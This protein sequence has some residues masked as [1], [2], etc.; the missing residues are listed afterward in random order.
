MMKGIPEP[1]PPG[2]CWRSS[3][4]RRA[5][6][7]AST[8]R[9]W[10]AG[11]SSAGS[12][13]R[14]RTPSARSLRA[15]HAIGPAGVGKSRLVH[16]FVAESRTGDGDPRAGVCRTAKESRSGRSSGPS[17][18]RG[19]R[20]QRDSSAEAR[21]KLAG[22]LPRDGDDAAL[23]ATRSR[24]LLGLGTQLA[25][26]RRRSGRSG[27]C[28]STSRRPAARGRLRRHPVGRVDVPRSAS[29]TSQTGS[30]ALP[31][32]IVC[33]ARPEIQ[34]SAPGWAAANVARS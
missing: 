22:L 31:V 7:E 14:S 12:T 20:A 33:I 34:E 26:S 28:S 21:T 18:R 13:R 30:D 19:D 1:C 9:S 11:R 8:L 27:S 23:V 2:G 24:G 5:G 3:R 15:R 16:E 17:G 25:G 4:R 32:L 6:R 29:S 10:A